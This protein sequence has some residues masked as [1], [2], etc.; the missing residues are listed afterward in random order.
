M[1]LQAY[2]NCNLISNLQV[3]PVYLT[4]IISP[5][6]S[7]GY[8]GFTSVAPPLPYI[9][10][11]VSDNSKTLSP[12]SFKLGTDMYLDWERNTNLRWV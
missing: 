3:V 8:T 10:T 12:I 2:Q 9:L 5:D 4:I 7:E 11:C 6:D 1:I